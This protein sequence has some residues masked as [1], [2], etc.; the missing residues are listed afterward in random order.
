MLATTKNKTVLKTSPKYER[1]GNN[2]ASKT[3]AIKSCF[4]FFRDIKEGNIKS[5]INP[6]TE[7]SAIIIPMAVFEPTLCSTTI[8]KTYPIVPSAML[9]RKNATKKTGIC[10]LTNRMG[11]FLLDNALI[12]I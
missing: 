4:Q 8:G 12:Y 2:S 10:V 6:V 3:Q 7:D 1:T 11:K 5:H 9:I